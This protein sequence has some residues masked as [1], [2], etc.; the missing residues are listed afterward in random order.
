[1]L[2][3]C[4]ATSGR[5]SIWSMKCIVTSIPCHVISKLTSGRSL[6]RAKDDG[7][8]AAVASPTPPAKLVQPRRVGMYC[9][10]I[11]HEL[12]KVRVAS[13]RITANLILE[14]DRPWCR[15]SQ[16]H[17]RIRLGCLRSLKPSL[18]DS[19]SSLLR[20]QAASGCRQ[21]NPLKR[22]KSRSVV[23]HSL[24]DSIARA[25]SHASGTRLPRASQFLHSSTKRPQ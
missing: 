16:R 21:R 22:L 19:L 15:R 14:L 10:T 11:S 20:V 24:P 4:L 1:M 9:Q 13:L 23:I 7:Q 5:D 3:G 6:R 12:S 8:I 25:A 17:D 2:P 18:P